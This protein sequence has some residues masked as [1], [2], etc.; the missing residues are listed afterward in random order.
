MTQIGWIVADFT[1]TD[2]QYLF[3]AESAKIVIICV[4]CVLLR[5]TFLKILSEVTF[6]L[7]MPYPNISEPD[8]FPMIL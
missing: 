8:F 2:D 6:I 4:I 7:Q 1:D 3:F 5:Q